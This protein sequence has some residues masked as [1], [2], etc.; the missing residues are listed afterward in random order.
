MASEPA[1]TVSSSVTTDVVT[2][3]PAT[4]TYYNTGQLSTQTTNTNWNNF[5]AQR[6]TTRHNLRIATILNEAYTMDHT[7][8]VIDFPPPYDMPPSYEVATGQAPPSHD[9]YT[10]PVHFSA[11]RRDNFFHYPGDILAP[12]RQQY[13]SPPLSLWLGK[14]AG[15][16]GPAC[17]DNTK[18]DNCL[19]AVSVLNMLLCGLLFGIAAVIN[20]MRAR[21]AHIAG[22]Y[23]LFIFYQGPDFIRMKHTAIL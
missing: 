11:C 4:N 10:R 17:E 22:R 8:E 16:G 21:K 5:S 20:C 13:S 1:V 12:Q 6:T 15:S 19:L 18:P 9:N 7:C 3:I 2:T 23:S 14:C